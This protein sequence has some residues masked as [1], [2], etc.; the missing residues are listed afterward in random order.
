MVEA[1]HF[2]PYRPQQETQSII[3]ESKR[4]AKAEKPVTI[5]QIFYHL[6]SRNILKNTER[7]YKKLVRI[8]VRARK[9]GF[10]PFE[11][12]EDRSR[13]PLILPLYPNIL[14]Y[15]ENKIER[16][17]K[18]TWQN[19]P[20]FIIILLEKEALAGIVWE[21]ASIYNVPV[22]PTKGYSSWSMF[23]KD[24]RSQ[25]QKYSDKPLVVLVLGDYDPSGTDIP[26]D[27][28]EKL[29][30]LGVR[31]TVVERIALTREQVVEYRLPPQM[32]KR[33][34]PRYERFAQEYGEH[35]VELDALRPS[36]LRNIVEEAILKYL[37][38]E[39]FVKDWEI[40]QQEKEK[41]REAMKDLE[42]I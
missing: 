19:Q 3:V 9:A 17:Y 10:V 27:H 41:L 39:A 24:I 12:I 34:D 26:R 30:F 42:E 6:V 8:L 31:P 7:E 15:I 22:F 32:A 21:V 37:D 2:E 23:Y 14:D 18:D 1:I 28:L 4:F 16:Y 11:W 25:V 33:D 36:T 20:C 13:N 38:H 35:S 29:E 40:E 5:R